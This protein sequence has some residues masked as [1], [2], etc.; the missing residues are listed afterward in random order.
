M[1]EEQKRLVQASFEQVLPIGEKAAQL[2]YARL[3]ELEPDLRRLF[4]SDLKAQGRALMGMLWVAVDG[5]DRLD[6][7]VPAV[8]NLGRRHA[9][10]G[11]QAAH[12]DI[13]GQALLDTLERGL[14]PA[15]TE[16]VRDAW[17]AA[18]GLL[19]GVMRDAAGGLTASEQ[20]R[21]ELAR[22]AIGAS[23]A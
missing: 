2:F 6:E 4:R 10:Y 12:Y 18:Y 16:D 20:T 19:A 13:V 15:F 8:Q 7:I 21:I 17:A 9:G 14:G 11:V 5:L 22:E 23:A 1:N 3:F